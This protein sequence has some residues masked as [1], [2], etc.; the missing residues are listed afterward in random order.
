[1]GGRGLDVG[2]DQEVVRLLHH[3]GVVLQVVALVVGHLP[4]SPALHQP[5]RDDHEE[6]EDETA[7]HTA[8]DEAPLQVITGKTVNINLTELRPVT[9]CSLQ[10]FPLSSLPSLLQLPQPQQTAVTLQGNS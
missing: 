7:P 6:D 3:V 2:G 4:L 9:G 8:D 1:M 5:G 10:Y